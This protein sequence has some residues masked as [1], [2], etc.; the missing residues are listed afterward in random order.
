MVISAAGGVVTGPIDAVFLHEAK[1]P[2]IKLAAIMPAKLLLV[3]M[4]VSSAITNL[5]Y[6]RVACT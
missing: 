6:V 4:Q 3:H 1:L 5:I 2:S